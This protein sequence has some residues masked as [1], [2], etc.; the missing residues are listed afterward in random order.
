MPFGLTNAPAVF[1]DLMNRVCK[2]YFDKFFIVFINDILIYS[3]SKEDHEV[4]LKLVLELLKK[5]K[6]FANFSKYEFWLQEEEAFQTLKDNL[7]HAPILSLSDGIEDFVVY[8]DVSNQGLGCVLMQRGKRHYLYGTKSVIYTDHKSLQHIFDQKELN[9]CR[10]RWIELFN[11]NECENRYHPRK[12][13]VVADVFSEASKVENATTKMLR[14][15]DQLM[16]RKEYRETLGMRLD[17]STTYHPRM[18][19]QSKHTIQTLED[20]LRACVIDFGG[21]WDTHLPLVEF[22]YNNSYHLSIRCAPF[23]ALY[24]KKCRSH[25]LWAEFGENRLIGLEMVQETI[26]KVVLIKKRLKADRDRQKSYA[27][28][29]REPIEFEVD[30]KCY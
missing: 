14:G 23:E 4:H 27:D 21:S 8:C 25:V 5:E 15:L 29:R 24:E 22:S 6:L 12:A 7:C 13:N 17:M 30:K 26:D 10:R 11:D 16:E 2:M 3:K 28:N 19:E 18:N 20:M 9:M 1:M